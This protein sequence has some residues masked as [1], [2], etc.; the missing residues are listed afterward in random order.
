[1][2]P[3]NRVAERRVLLEE[4]VGPRVSLGNSGIAYH[5]RM[6][7]NP[8]VDIPALF[9]TIVGLIT[10]FVLGGLIGLER[11]VGQ[12]T[13]GLRANVLVR[14]SFDDFCRPWGAIERP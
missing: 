3:A 8:Y 10:A 14:G 9:N 4:P 1:M 2:L 12:R 13:T 6:G 11:Q 5:W 7:P